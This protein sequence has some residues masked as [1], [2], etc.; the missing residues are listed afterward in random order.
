MAAGYTYTTSSGTSTNTTTTQ[1]IIFYSISG[2]SNSTWNTDYIAANYYHGRNSY[3]RP[4]LN[5]TYYIDDLKMYTPQSCEL[6]MLA[7][8]LST[9]PDWQA[10]IVELWA[11]PRH[12]H[13]SV[14]SRILQATDAALSEILTWAFEKV[15]PKP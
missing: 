11:D 2:S 10:R 8:V 5:R 7:A 4:L 3:A 15:L 1:D 9:Y 12:H 14:L 13:R 6:R